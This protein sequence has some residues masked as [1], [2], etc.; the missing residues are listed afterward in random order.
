L[1]FFAARFDI[2]LA[3]YLSTQLHSRFNDENL[4]RL[5]LILH[6]G[7]EIKLSLSADELN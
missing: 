4:I 7:D 2:V 5:T 6:G 1:C 3:F